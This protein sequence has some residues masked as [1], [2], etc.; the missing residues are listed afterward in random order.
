MA[1][2]IV[3]NNPLARDALN[4]IFFVEYRAE[5]AAE[6]LTRARDYI[7]AGGRLLTHPLSGGIAPGETPYK[8]VLVSDERGPLDYDSLS[9]IERAIETCEKFSPRAAPE[10]FLNDYME[11]D[12]AVIKGALKI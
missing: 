1:G 11:L 5:S 6:L 4:K 12:L 9:M 3:T 2:T 7:H 10:N 8:T